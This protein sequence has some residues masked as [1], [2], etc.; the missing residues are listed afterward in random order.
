M[1]MENHMPD[2]AQPCLPPLPTVIYYML[3]CK[4]KV[5]KKA[6]NKLHNTKPSAKYLT[7]TTFN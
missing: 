2:T 6:H 3:G 4:V 5:K 7:I 1:L